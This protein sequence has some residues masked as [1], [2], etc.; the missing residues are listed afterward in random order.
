MVACWKKGWITP[1]TYTQVKN[2]FGYIGR[3]SGY[4]RYFDEG[5]FTKAELEAAMN[6]LYLE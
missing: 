2:E 3:R 1:P 6:N 4:N 5:M